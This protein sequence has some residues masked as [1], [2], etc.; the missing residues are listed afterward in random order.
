MWCRKQ[1]LTSI[2]E[3][4]HTDSGN[5]IGVAFLLTAPLSETHID[6]SKKIAVRIVLVNL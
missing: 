2:H 6:K 4:S 1:L 5:G 3:K